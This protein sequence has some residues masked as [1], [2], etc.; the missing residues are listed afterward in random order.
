MVVELDRVAFFIWHS[1]NLDLCVGL[2]HSRL[3]SD[4]NLASRR[5]QLTHLSIHQRAVTQRDGVA[6]PLGG[7]RDIA[8]VELKRVLQQRLQ[9][10][11]RQEAWL[12]QAAQ[13]YIRRRGVVD[14]DQLDAVHFLG[15]NQLV[16]VRR[17]LQLLLRG[18]E[19]LHD[20]LV[21]DVLVLELVLLEGALRFKANLDRVGRRH[22]Y[23]LYL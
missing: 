7:G 21:A 11:L 22:Y 1:P 18:Q 17:H 10:A 3:I 15:A 14:V 8:S 16:A 13:A 23:L 12:V 4:L 2:Y 5:H 9:L 19:L 20:F 6:E